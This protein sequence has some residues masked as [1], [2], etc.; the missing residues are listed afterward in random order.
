MQSRYFGLMSELI[1][2]RGVI[3]DI[4]TKKGRMDGL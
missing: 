2:H 4:E 1:K 3:S